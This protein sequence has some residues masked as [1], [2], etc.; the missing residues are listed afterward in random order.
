MTIKHDRNFDDLF[1]RFDSKIYDTV[2]GEWRLRLLKEDLAQFV[3][4]S[5]LDVWDA[6]CG[7]GQI[8][9]WLAEQGHQLT[10][11][12]LSEKMLN[13]AK[14]NFEQANITANFYQQSAQSLASELP[15]FDLVICHAVL[16]WL[17]EPISSLQMIMDKVKPNGYLSLL[18]YNRNAMVYSNVLKGGWR[19]PPI[20][21]DS[22]IG[23]GNKLT[24]PNPQFPHEIIDVIHHA[25]FT[26]E[27]HTGV[28]I[29]NDYMSQ[30]ARDNSDQAVLFELEHKYC[31]MPVYRD[32]GRYIH[33]LL[34]RQI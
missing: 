25:G 28:R 16:E 14:V 32:M 15:Q 21:N 27:T 3:S 12:D 30:Q 18:F 33:L 24:P 2:K 9:L 11:C 6:G 8:S 22:Y 20:L 34:K 23:K 26:V 5:Q 7:Q 19:L 17:S 4:A 31:R 10:L 1:E 29:F 13:T